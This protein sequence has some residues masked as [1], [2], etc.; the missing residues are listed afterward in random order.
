[1]RR[2]LSAL[3]HNIGPFIPIIILWEFAVRLEIWPRTFVPSPTVVPQA[4]EQ[5]I[6]RA[7]LVSQVGLTLYRVLVAA[8]I[9]LLLGVGMGIV[10]SINKRIYY[11]LKDLIDFLQSVGEVGW[12]PLFVIWSGFNDRTIIFAVGYTVFFPVFYGVIS[13]FERVPKNLVDSVRSLGGSRR[14]V[15]WDVWVPGAL[16]YIIT[17]FRTGVGFGWR[18]VIIAEML[19]AQRGLGVVLF[20][21]RQFFRVDWVLVGMVVAGVIWLILDNLFLKRIESRTIERWGMQVRPD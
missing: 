7:D 11:S 20:N 8:V 2:R 10:I 13:G 6:T 14:H 9:G 4:F 5:L 12:L 3:V 19:I 17:G 18:T 15:L 1:M 21:A 16:P